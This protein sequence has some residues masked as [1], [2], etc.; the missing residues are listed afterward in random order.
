MG[1]DALSMRAV[2]DREFAAA[3]VEAKRRVYIAAG[4]SRGSA[5]AQTFR[6][7]YGTGSDVVARLLTIG[8]DG[9]HCAAWTPRPIVERT[10]MSYPGVALLGT[11]SPLLSGGVR[12]AMLASP[13]LRAKALCSDCR[14]VKPD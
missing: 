3:G 1:S 7:R 14:D 5:T 9:S 4:H 11:F 6:S 12:L 13:A 8:I 2:F 10:V